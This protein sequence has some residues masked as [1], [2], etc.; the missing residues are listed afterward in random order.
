MKQILLLFFTALLLIGCSKEEKKQDI[1]TALEEG[2]LFNSQMMLRSSV[3]TRPELDEEAIASLISN[4]EEEKQAAVTELTTT[5]T[6]TTNKTTTTKPITTT[7]SSV[8]TTTTTS[9]PVTTTNSTTVTTTSSA[10]DEA[11][12]YSSEALAILKLDNEKRASVG[13]GALVLDEALTKAASARAKELV[14]K[15]SH[16][17]PNGQNYSSILSS[18][19]VTS[20][21]TSE[22]IAWGYKT[23]AEAVNGWMNSAVHKANILDSNNRGFTKVGIG[24]YNNNGTKYWVQIFAK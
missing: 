17:R 7:K 18:F 6:S 19:G 12:V 8:V 22:I 20:T 9:I 10:S 14:T 15:F 23:P 13:K 5:V 24:Y 4:I 3:T 11:F 2:V 16:T 21:V 1:D